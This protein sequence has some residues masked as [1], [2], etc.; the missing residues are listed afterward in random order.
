MHK[1]VAELKLQIRAD[2]AEAMRGK[3]TADVS[4][5]RCMLGAIDDA[6]A[7][8][9]GARHDKYEVARFGDPSVEVPRKILTREELKHLIQSEIAAR[10]AASEERSAAGRHQDAA[11]LLREADI[12]K[13][14]LA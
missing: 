13:A 1:N 10:L 7:V 8:P 6:E 4:T 14:Y 12:L 11:I 5:L 2:L 9:A 3:R